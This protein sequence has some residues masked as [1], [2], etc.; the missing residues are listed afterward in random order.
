M[1]LS[2]VKVFDGLYFVFIGSPLV[3]NE[4]LAIDFI[5]RM[6]IRLAGNIY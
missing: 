6:V 1:A 5:A 2:D 4:L 3:V